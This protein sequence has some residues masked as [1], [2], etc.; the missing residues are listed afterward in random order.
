M[1]NEQEEKEQA[2]YERQLSIE[3]AEWEKNHGGQLELIK[4][5]DELKPN[6]FLWSYLLNEVEGPSKLTARAS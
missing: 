1:S 3:R 5:L 2:D 6:W 4:K